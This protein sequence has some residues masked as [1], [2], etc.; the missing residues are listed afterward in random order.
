MASIDEVT[1]AIGRALAETAFR[2]FSA[3]P[4]PKGGA[5]K[6]ASSSKPAKP[7]KPKKAAAKAKSGKARGKTSGKKAGAAARPARARP[8]GRKTRVKARG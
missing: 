7:A 5:A 2:P 8:G 6:K 4:R 1:A 3:K